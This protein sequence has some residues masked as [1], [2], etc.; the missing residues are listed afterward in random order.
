MLQGFLLH[1]THE[2]N[3]WSY[4]YFMLHLSYTDPSDYTALELHVH[5]LVLVPQSFTVCLDSLLVVFLI[6]SFIRFVLFLVPSSKPYLVH[7]CFDAVASVTGRAS[8][9]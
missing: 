1:V 4:M 6:S 5:R 7:Q 2:H 3:M 9:L 8:D